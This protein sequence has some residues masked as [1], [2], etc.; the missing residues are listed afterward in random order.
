ML[1]CSGIADFTM[2]DAHNQNLN[3]NAFRAFK[4][5]HF[6]VRLKYRSEI[7]FLVKKKQI[8]E[9]MENS[10]RRNGTMTAQAKINIR[11]IFRFLF[12]CIQF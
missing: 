12:L 11:N 3:R 2:S 10:C 9:L 4:T 5:H 8:Q 1:N 6:L 7:Y